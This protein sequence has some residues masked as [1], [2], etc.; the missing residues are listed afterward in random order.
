ML[1]AHP[2]EFRRDVVALARRRE[3]LRA[4]HHARRDFESCL[5]R[6]ATRAEIDEAARRT[7]RASR[8]RSTVRRVAAH[9]PHTS[10]HAHPPAG[11]RTRWRASS[12]DGD[13]P[14]AEVVHGAAVSG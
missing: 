4:L 5:F 13:L 11:P 9:P 12:R 10:G 1:R 6:W 8:A 3:M 2:R 14:G 7:S